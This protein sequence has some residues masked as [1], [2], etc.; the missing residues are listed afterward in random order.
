MISVASL[1]S[2]DFILISLSVILHILSVF[3]SPLIGSVRRL[4]DCGVRWG[5]CELVDAG[6]NPR[7][8]VA[9]LVGGV[10]RLWDGRPARLSFNH[11]YEGWKLSATLYQTDL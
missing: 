6:G 2:V 7:R 3:L 1:I 10:L 11:I 5:F 4:I 9:P 8:A